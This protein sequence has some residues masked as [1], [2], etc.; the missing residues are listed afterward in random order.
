MLPKF[1]Q[2]NLWLRGFARLHGVCPGEDATAHRRGVRA[3][4]DAVEPTVVVRLWLHLPLVHL[5]PEPLCLD[6]ILGG[7]MFGEALGEI[8]QPRFQGVEFAHLLTWSN[9]TS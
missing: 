8:A 6:A 5:A 1:G 3:A 2:R 9:S 7:E 4:D